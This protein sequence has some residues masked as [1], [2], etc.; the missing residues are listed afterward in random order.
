MKPAFSTADQF[1]ATL[2]AC[3]AKA[4]N[5]GINELYAYG[6]VAT[7]NAIAVLMECADLPPK[8]MHKAKQEAAA[9]A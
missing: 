5:T 8:A 6:G 7:E 3:A 2:N 4:L 9:N 1:Q